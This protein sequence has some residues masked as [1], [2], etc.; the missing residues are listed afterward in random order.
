MRGGV[1]N[2]QID[3]TEIVLLLRVTQRATLDLRFHHRVHL[4]TRETATERA[5]T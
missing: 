1:G 3:Q 4:S 2:V 5:D